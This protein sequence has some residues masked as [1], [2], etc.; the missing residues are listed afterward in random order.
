MF[1][2]KSC[3]CS[4]TLKC[5]NKCGKLWNSRLKS[6]RTVRNDCGTYSGWSLKRKNIE[7]AGMSLWI[8]E[9]SWNMF[10]IPPSC[11]CKNNVWINKNQLSAL[12]EQ[13]RWSTKINLSIFWTWS[14]LLEAGFCPGWSWTGW[15]R[16]NR[17][18]S[19]R[20]L[21]SYVSYEIKS[22]E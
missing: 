20:C 8:K 4:R 12:Q 3:N 17:P 11:W 19:L 10:G 22:L 21:Y 16:K 1:W 9:E 6:G 18:K 5:R 13:K 2:N 7:E 15:P 14:G